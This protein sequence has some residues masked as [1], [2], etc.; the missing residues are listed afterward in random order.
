[1]AVQVNPI[2]QS[3]P[4]T[5]AIQDPAVRRFAQAVDDALRALRSE[6]GAVE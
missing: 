2:T 4:A 1:M 6:E 5:T 3:L